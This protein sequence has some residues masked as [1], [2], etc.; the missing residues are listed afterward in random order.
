MDNRRY[1]FSPVEN[2]GRPL[3]PDAQVTPTF[4]GIVQVA[5]ERQVLPRIYVPSS[6]FSHPS[7]LS[8][9]LNPFSQWYFSPT[10]AACAPAANAFRLSWPFLHAQKLFFSSPPNKQTC[11][12]LRSYVVYISTFFAGEGKGFIPWRSSCR[13]KVADLVCCLKRQ[14]HVWR[15]HHF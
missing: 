13:L 1:P 3:R 6:C 9:S 5:G 8:F 12:A 11:N 15:A 4:R 14:S 10:Q 7:L 2:P